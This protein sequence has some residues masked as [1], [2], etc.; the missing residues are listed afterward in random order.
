[1]ASNTLL[2][3]MLEEL[4]LVL[5]SSQ[6]TI[7]IDVKSGRS[8]PVLKNYLES[9]LVPITTISHLMGKAGDESSIYEQESIENQCHELLER[10]INHTRH[11]MY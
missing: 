8:L 11:I 9:A 2:N 3:D 1:M 4:L 10:I 7:Y 5:D 6:V